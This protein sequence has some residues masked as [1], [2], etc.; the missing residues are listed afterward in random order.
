MLWFFRALMFQSTAREAQHHALECGLGDHVEEQVVTAGGD[1]LD[2]ASS[3]DCAR[4]LVRGGSGAE[5]NLPELLPGGKFLEHAGGVAAPATGE[6]LGVFEAAGDRGGRDVVTAVQQAFAV[7]EQARLLGEGQGNARAPAGLLGGTRGDGRVGAAGEE[8]RLDFDSSHRAHVEAT[9][10]ADDGLE[11]V[12]GG[13]CDEDDRGP[14]GRFFQNFEEGVLGIHGELFGGFDDNDTH[15][16]FEREAGDEVDKAADLANQDIAGCLVAVVAGAGAGAAERI[17]DADFD[18]VGVG[19]GGDEAAGTALATGQ[20]GRIAGAALET[21]EQHG[22]ETDKRPFTGGFG[23]IEEHGMGRRRR[24]REAPQLCQ[25]GSMSDEIDHRLQG[26]SSRAGAGCYAR[27]KASGGEMNKEQVIADLNEILS[28]EYTA[29]LQYT[30]EEFVLKGIE[31]QQFAPMFRAEATESL[32]HAQMV[33]AKVVALGGAPTT[34]VG[35]IDTSTE[36]RA[37]LESNLKLETRAA[38]M[39]SRALQHVGDADIALRVMLENQVEI[40]RRSVEE[41]QKLLGM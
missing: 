21:I 17:A 38:E 14:I 32:G 31:R 24:G 26:N 11:E 23:A 28:L 16:C 7:I 29:V 37:I 30:Y 10:A 39:Y 34:A 40:E 33:G 19:A 5:G 8:R 3:V 12:L 1:G 25:Q 35:P 20:A 27:E 41:L 2:G 36:L 4:G 9:A 22:I 18:E 6:V 13:R 15:I